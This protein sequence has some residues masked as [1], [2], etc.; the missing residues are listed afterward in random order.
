MLRSLIEIFKGKKQKLYC[1]F[2][3]FSQAFDSVWRNGLWCKLKLLL[4]SVKGKF[5][6]IIYKMYGNIKSC[7]KFNNEC[8]I[9]FA[10]KNGVRQG[11]NL[12]PL[13]FA[14]YLIIS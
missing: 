7:V 14:M 11:E 6:Q 12:S 1:V 4:N 3:D 8:S 10:C 9:F 13:L 5:F 2:V